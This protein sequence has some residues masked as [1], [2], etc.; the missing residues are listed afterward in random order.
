MRK[1]RAI[2]SHLLRAAAVTNPF[3][4]GTSV[5]LFAPVDK[6]CIGADNKRLDSKSDQRLRMPHNRTWRNTAHELG[7]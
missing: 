6:E 4:S 7:L 5:D 2:G 3:Q 1:F